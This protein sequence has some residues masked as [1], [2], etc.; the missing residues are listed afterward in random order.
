MTLLPVA[1]FGGF[2]AVGVGRRV[3]SRL[4]ELLV[5]VR[6]AAARFEAD[7]WSGDDC[8]RLAEELARAAKACSAASARAAARAIACNAGDVEWVA[9]T[10]GATPGQARDSL[11]TTRA[12]SECPATRDAVA[13]G[14][15]SMVQAREIVR[16]QAAVPGSEDAL[17]KVAETRG[18][19]GLREEARR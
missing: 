17:L 2:G 10:T 1:S 11:T 14:A 6:D 7:R 4:R 9:R 3:V 18:M 13:S 12:L 5:E 19:A 8:A 16:A 15:V